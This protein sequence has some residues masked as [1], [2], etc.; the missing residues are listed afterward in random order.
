MKFNLTTS[1]SS[2]S[3]GMKNVQKYIYTPIQNIHLKRV[4][5]VHV[6]SLKT[7]SYV[8]VSKLLN[9]V[10][11]EGCLLIVWPF[12]MNGIVRSATFCC[13]KQRTPVINLWRRISYRLVVPQRSRPWCPTTTLSTWR[14]LTCS[15]TWCSDP[16]R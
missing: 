5:Q 16:E 9:N 15:L 6:F 11:G 13:S 7:K 8:L 10:S 12:W 14:W 2:F 1:S 4:L 3:G